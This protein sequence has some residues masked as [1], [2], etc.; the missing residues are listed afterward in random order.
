MNRADAIDVRKQHARAVKIESM[1]GRIRNDITRTQSHFSRTYRQTQNGT[2]AQKKTSWNVNGIEGGCFRVL[3]IKGKN[4]LHRKHYVHNTNRK[5][6]AILMENVPHT[7][8][9]AKCSCVIIIWL[10]WQCQ[11][12]AMDAA[13]SWVNKEKR[14]SVHTNPDSLNQFMFYHLKSGLENGLRSAKL[15]IK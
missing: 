15:I 5:M 7:N 11:I 14:I 9:R 13:P 10:Y 1:D 12:H 6:Q 4:N 2:H 8:T 3:T